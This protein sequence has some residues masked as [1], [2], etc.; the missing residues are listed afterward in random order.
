MTPRTGTPPA[1]GT[2]PDRLT[3]VS[4][5]TACWG[6]EESLLTLLD[7]V[8]VPARVA[9]PEGE[10]LERARARGHATLAL[11]HRDVLRLT[12]LGTEVG[13]AGT[14]GAMLLGAAALAGLPLWGRGPVVSFSMWLHLPL[15][16]AGRL[17]GQ[18]VVLDLHDGPFTPAGAAV[19]SAATYAAG[20]SVSV[21][22]TAL[23][24]VGRFPHR[25]VRVVPRPVA[26]PA[27]SRGG[28]GASGDRA[29]GGPLRALVVGRLDREKRVDVVL[30]AHRRLL[31]EGRDVALEVV[32]APLRGAEGLEE[33]RGRWPDADLVGRLPHDRVLERIAAS[34]LLVS[35]ATGEAF[36]R[37]V[38]EA[39]L[40]GVPALVVGGG[41][42]ELVRDGR[43][44]LHAPDP[45]VEGV[46]AGL[47][48][49]DDDRAALA[50]LGAAAQAEL[51]VLC[52]PDAVARQWWEAVSA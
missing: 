50:R 24:H 9:A 28:A 25:R 47:R 29:A 43:T 20:R 19:Q 7:G 33:L 37:T 13:A 45:E 49:A 42:A 26:I 17:R 12:G 3:V 40:L 4:L 21:S 35:A 16:L 52:D 8:P 51:S 15:A 38:A 31:D 23:E 39:A 6:A 36:G 10:L 18:G 30:A 46:A 22:R 5:S 2:T 27:G 48:R 32:G 44:G 41:P 34:D 11:R 1:T 14:P